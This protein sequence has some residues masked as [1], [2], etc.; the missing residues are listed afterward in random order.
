M[1]PS[2]DMKARAH[3]AEVFETDVGVIFLNL[4]QRIRLIALS[5]TT[6]AKELNGNVSGSNS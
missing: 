6:K 5:F 4:E 2:G 3:F 1:F